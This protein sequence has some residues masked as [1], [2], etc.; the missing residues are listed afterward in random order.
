MRKASDGY[1]RLV[2]AIE[3]IRYCFFDGRNIIPSCIRRRTEAATRSRRRRT[4]STSR[5]ATRSNEGESMKATW[6][7]ISGLYVNGIYINESEDYLHLILIGRLFGQ[8]CLLQPTS[9]G[10]FLVAGQKA[11]Y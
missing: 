6:Y 5:S 1:P 4:I 2:A 9:G 3:L 7:K 8:D 10:P 11:V